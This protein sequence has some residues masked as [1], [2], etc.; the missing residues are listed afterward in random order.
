MRSVIVRVERLVRLVTEET[1]VELFI[2]G[3]FEI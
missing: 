2:N 3:V 1:T